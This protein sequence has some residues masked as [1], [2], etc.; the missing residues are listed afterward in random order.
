MPPGTGLWVPARYPHVTR[1]PAGLAHAR[2][3]PAG[4]RRGAGPGAA[5]VIA[6]SPLLRELILAVCDEPVVWDE[7]GPVRHVAALAL[8]EI[9]RAAT[10]P[11]A[12]PACRDPRLQRVAE[13]LVADP[14]DPR[15]LGA[16]SPRPRAPRCARWRGC[17]AA[18][19]A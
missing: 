11:I 17:S 13:A 2:A 10:R 16:H 12:L 14:A 8:H 9:G 19:P 6:V 7:R 18:R 5:T 3:V 15:D 4:G 1:M